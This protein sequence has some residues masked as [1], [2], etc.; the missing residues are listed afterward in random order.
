MVHQARK[1]WSLAAGMALAV[2]LGAASGCVAQTGDD[3]ATSDA[4]DVVAEKA[5]RAEIA[6]AQGTVPPSKTS[7]AQQNQQP[8]STGGLEPQPVPWTAGSSTLLPGPAP[9]TPEPT[10]AA[11]RDPLVWVAR[12]AAERTEQR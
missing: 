11:A 8:G 6:A 7:I 4:K 2:L 1:I 12:S 3:E 9:T 10:S 5:P